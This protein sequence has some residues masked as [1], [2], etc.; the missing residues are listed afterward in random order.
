MGA[1]WFVLTMIPML[2]LIGHLM[3]YYLFL[4]VAGFS[5]LFG[6]AMS[7]LKDVAGVVLPGGVMA[8]VLIV[9]GYTSPV[10][11]REHPALGRS[12]EAAQTTMADLRRMHPTLGPGSILYINDDAETLWFYQSQGELLRMEYGEENIRVLYSSLEEDIPADAGNG[13]VLV[14]RFDGRHLIE[15]TEIYRKDP[16]R[17]IRY[18]DPGRSELTVSA[19]EAGVGDVYSVRING[20]SNESVTIAYS[21]NNQQVQTFEAPLDLNGRTAFRVSEVTPKGHY[22]FM[23]FRRSGASKWLRASAEIE[24]H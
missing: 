22:R 10:L 13:P 16:L 5:L 21:R 14:F 11:A 19:T 18:G 24:V 12:A 2:P 6:R 20:I 3:P 4:P 15:E 23:G 17:F 1:G 7:T 9:A 8:F